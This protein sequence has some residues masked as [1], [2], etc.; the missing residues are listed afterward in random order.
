MT[1]QDNIDIMLVVNRERKRP[2]DEGPRCDRL[3][4]GMAAARAGGLGSGQNIV[5]MK[6]IMQMIVHPNFRRRCQYTALALKAGSV[7]TPTA[8][9][10]LINRTFKIRSRDSY[11]ENHAYRGMLLSQGLACQVL[12]TGHL[13]TTLAPLA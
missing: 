10:K 11:S 3:D 12:S 6:R 5:C 8:A 7:A 2:E 9:K 1:W 13:V 4:K